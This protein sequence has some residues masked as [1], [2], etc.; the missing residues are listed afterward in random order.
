MIDKINKFYKNSDGTILGK[1]AVDRVRDV[2][3]Y[4]IYYSKVREHGYPKS[5]SV[6]VLSGMCSAISPFEGVEID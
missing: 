6:Q 4:G 5:D 2:L 3:E 1:T